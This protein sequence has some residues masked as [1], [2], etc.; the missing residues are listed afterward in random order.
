MSDQVNSPS[1]Y[2][3]GQIEAIQGIAASMSSTEF[4]G[5]CK[6][7]ILKYL[8]R[9]RYKGKP[10]EDLKKAQWYLQRLI[11]TLEK[12]AAEGS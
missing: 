5:Y 4:E 3:A 6:G 9:Y 10:L 11:D 12:D 1:H 2:K 8:W 7:N